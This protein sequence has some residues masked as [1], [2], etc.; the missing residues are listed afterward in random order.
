MHTDIRTRQINLQKFAKSKAGMTIWQKEAAKTHR[1]TDNKGENLKYDPVAGNKKEDGHE[2]RLVDALGTIIQRMTCTSADKQVSTIQSRIQMVNIIEAYMARFLM[3]LENLGYVMADPMPVREDGELTFESNEGGERY[4][5]FENLEMAVAAMKAPHPLHAKRCMAIKYLDAFLNLASDSLIEEEK[6]GT[7]AMVIFSDYGEALR[8]VLQEAYTICTRENNRLQRAIESREGDNVVIK[9]IEADVE[10]LEVFAGMDQL[11]LRIAAMPAERRQNTAKIITMVNFDPKTFE[12]TTDELQQWAGIV[13]KMWTTTGNTKRVNDFIKM[14]ATCLNCL[15]D[16]GGCASKEEKVLERSDTVGKLADLFL[17]RKDLGYRVIQQGNVKHIKALALAV[18]EMSVHSVLQAIVLH[19]QYV[20]AGNLV[21][22]LYSRTAPFTRMVEKLEDVA[23]EWMDLEENEE[24]DRV[25]FLNICGEQTGDLETY[26][27]EEGN[28]ISVK[29]NLRY[30]IAVILVQDST[31]PMSEVLSWHDTGVLPTQTFR[32]GEHPIQV[33]SANIMKD[34]PCEIVTL[35]QA[36]AML[37]VRIEAARGA[38]EAGHSAF[39]Q[40]QMANQER[41]KEERERRLGITERALQQT[42]DAAE[43]DAMELEQ[44]QAEEREFQEYKDEKQAEERALQEARATEAEGMELEQQQTEERAFQEAMELEHDKLLR[45]DQLARMEA[46][47]R[48]AGSDNT[49]QMAKAVAE[50]ERRLEVQRLEQIALNEKLE[51]QQASKAAKEADMQKRAAEAKATAASKQ[52]AINNEAAARAEA[53]MEKEKQDQQQLRARQKELQKQEKT[54]AAAAR[55]T[56]KEI[57]RQEKEAKEMEANSAIESPE[58]SR[59]KQR[60][61]GDDGADVAPSG[62]AAAEPG[63]DEERS[64]PKRKSPQSRLQQNEVDVP[65]EETTDAELEA[66][67]EDVPMEDGIIDTYMIRTAIDTYNDRQ[68]FTGKEDE[69]SAEMILHDLRPMT[70]TSTEHLKPQVIQLIAL[71]EADIICLLKVWKNPKDD[72]EL[73]ELQLT[74]GALATALCDPG[75]E[76]MQSKLGSGRTAFGAR[77]VKQ[78]KRGMSEEECVDLL[79]PAIDMISQPIV[80]RDRGKT[81]LRG[82]MEGMM[83]AVRRSK[84]GFGQSLKKYQIIVSNCPGQ[85]MDGTQGEVVRSWVNLLENEANP[86]LLQATEEVRQKVKGENGSASAHLK[87][88]LET[89][90][91]TGGAASGDLRERRIDVAT[92]TGRWVVGASPVEGDKWVMVLERGERR[93]PPVLVR[94]PSTSPVS[95]AR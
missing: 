20:I 5:G 30:A 54:A 90:C 10:K 13:Q 58:K 68:P 9:F 81:T 21:N 63:T 31:V 52:Q 47:A 66:L 89:V 56:K 36:P 76:A 37:S 49:A 1:W 11:T 64:T 12:Q 84:D 7:R 6:R 34:G 17:K 19:M 27:R 25:L 94:G 46:A 50:S 35:L 69:R 16:E 87:N 61:R 83:E 4:G 53:Q 59:P 67:M 72:A 48:A 18:R 62:G 43:A 92:V 45:A 42:R 82:Q 78:R 95:R 3:M 88:L 32:R 93:V 39:I 57:E 86:E 40:E 73:S 29:E 33:I 71:I 80:E 28:M 24:E 41:E 60:Q 14:L 2:N 15:R 85:G 22:G 38:Q 75:D 26:L 77:Y 8:A 23:L 65:M 91:A 70:A 51:Q 55:A 44:K 79:I 74:A